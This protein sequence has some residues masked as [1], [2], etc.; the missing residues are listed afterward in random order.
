MSLLNHSSIWGHHCS[1]VFLAPA[2]SC[3]KMRSIWLILTAGLWSQHHFQTNPRDCPGMNCF[4]GG[5]QE[6]FQEALVLQR[7]PA[8]MVEEEEFAH[9]LLGTFF[10]PDACRAFPLG[11]GCAP[12]GEPEPEPAA[13]QEP[14]HRSRWG[15]LRNATSPRRRKHARR[16]WQSPVSRRA[17]SHD[18]TTAHGG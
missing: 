3:F 8:G 4:H 7:Q 10:V 17:P 9:F 16:R 14:R 18:P 11:E 15:E 5:S 12:H 13:P 2:A 1:N 6:T